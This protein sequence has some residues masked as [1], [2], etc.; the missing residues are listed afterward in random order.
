MLR[1]GP[2]LLLADMLAAALAWPLAVWLVDEAIPAHAQPGLLPLLAYPAAFILF[3]YALG[4][5]RRE[6]MIEPR[7]AIGRIP[8]AAGLGAATGF[9]S[10]AVLPE[11]FGAPGAAALFG[12]A[13]LAFTASAIVARGAFYFALKR[14]AFRRRLLVIGA[15]K[16]AWDMVW[17]LRNEGRSIGL[18]LAFVHDPRMGEID[19]RLAAENAGRIFDAAEGF[20]AIARR[21]RAE[22]IVV[23]PDERRGMPM[24]E[25]LSCRTAGFPVRE[26][27]RFLEAEIGRIDLKRLDI[28]SLLYADGFT[29]SAIDLALKRLLDIVA[30]ALMLFVTAP[31]LGVAALA[32]KL[33]DGGPVLYRQ[34]RVTRGGRIFRIMK[35]R[36]MTTDA[37][38]G[39]AVWAAKKDPRITRIGRFL[40]RT[41]LDELP[42]LVNV[43]RGDMSFVGP[44]PERPEFTCELARELPLYNERHLVR[45]GLTGWAQ[46]NYPYGASL[47]D[48]RSKLSYDLYYVKNFSVLF[49]VLIILQTL[50]VVLWPGGVR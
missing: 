26:Y 4:L 7:H 32:V 16:R 10:A 48:A 49:D 42:Q 6:A 12:A 9:V 31:F 33:E 17:L 39:G 18:D 27:H 8:L 47:D 41:R 29:Y 36:T 21:F 11:P 30:S 2:V 14:G 25:L 15:G 45:A 13:V 23:A 34:E 50:R 43:L 22:Q 44:R 37:E 5:Y 20:L 35:L 28:G 46:V 3:L 40:R 24:T 38:R 19:Q 1:A